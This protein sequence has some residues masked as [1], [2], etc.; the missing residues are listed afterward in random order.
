MNTNKKDHLDKVVERFNSDRIDG[1]KKIIGIVMDNFFRD[2]Q[3]NR[4]T[5]NNMRGLQ[6]DI[7]LA[8]DGKISIKEDGPE[9]PPQK[10]QKDEDRI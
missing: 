7:M 2:E 4:V 8:I 3:G 1:L 9:A 10:E 6:M 5:R